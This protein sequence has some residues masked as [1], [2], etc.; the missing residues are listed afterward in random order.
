MTMKKNEINVTFKGKG[1]FTADLEGY[2]IEIDKE[3][4]LGTRPKILMLASLAGCT[5][6]DIVDILE[7]MRV[8]FSEFSIKVIGNLTDETP[9]VYNKM[10]IL[11]TIKV[12]G[13]DQVKVAKAVHLSKDKYCGVSKMYEAF[14]DMS[15]EINYLD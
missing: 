1:H 15:F 7:K 2:K 12:S 9:S 10:S 13:E 11:Y 6:F 14:A 3:V 5:G 4:H 8:S